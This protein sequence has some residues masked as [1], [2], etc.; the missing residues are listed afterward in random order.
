MTVLDCNNFWSPTGGGVRRYHL[1][2]QDH[3]AALDDVRHVFVM[4]DRFT[5]TELCGSGSCIEHVRAVKEPGAS[6][7]RFIINA[8]L[9]RRIVHRHRPDVIEIGSPFF[10]PWL[11]RTAIWGLQP[12][13]ALIGFW[14][15][16]FPRTHAGRMLRSWPWPF[17]ILGEKSAWAWA[18]RAYAP[19]DA[20]FVASRRVGAN[21]MQNGLTRLY[22]T[23]LGVDV[24]CF[25]PGRRDAELV[26]R[27]KAGVPTRP[28]IF[29]PHRLLDEKGLG[30]LL[31]AYPALCDALPHPP[32]LVFANIGP[33]RSKVEAAVRRHTHVHYL[34]YIDQSSELARWYAS[35]DL[36]LALSAF[37]TFGLSAAEAMASGLALVGANEGGVAELIEDS[38]CG[39]TVPYG[40]V[41][42]L[43]TAI[44]NLVRENKLEERGLRGRQHVS[45]FT[46]N[47]TFTNEVA[48]YRD[49][50]YYLRQGKPVRRGFHTLTRAS[51]AVTK[52]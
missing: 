35:C 9:L 39:L 43:V 44:V 47:A 13:P 38:G 1:Q 30:C 36:A 19:F 40:D 22:Y 21:L 23:P 34:G 4:P 18:R 27:L 7:Y 2:K 24:D 46:W 20:L 16:D 26:D 14:H 8:R 6:D 41:E 42:A 5:G 10:L 50:L 28:T 33:G 12:R 32:A 15:N 3:L 11:I 51:T 29:F 37:E 31:A 45:R 25:Y 48:C 17:G 52:H 49:V